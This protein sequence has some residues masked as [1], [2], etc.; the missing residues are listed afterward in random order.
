M[1]DQSLAVRCE[2]AGSDGETPNIT[3]E[4]PP[5]KTTDR[6]VRTSRD[7][8]NYMQLMFADIFIELLRYDIA[9]VKES[10]ETAF[11]GVRGIRHQYI[12]QLICQSLLCWM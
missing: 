7:L 6:A 5:A 2:L 9:Y 4:T 3:D 10:S 8:G 1:A 11:F 12:L